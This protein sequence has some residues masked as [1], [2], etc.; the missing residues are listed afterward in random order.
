MNERIRKREREKE[1]E[2]VIKKEDNICLPMNQK[3]DNFVTKDL[4]EDQ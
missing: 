3:K 2:R 4:C 1:R